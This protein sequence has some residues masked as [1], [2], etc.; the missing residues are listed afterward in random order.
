MKMKMAACC[1]GI[2]A[3]GVLTVEGSTQVNLVKE[4]TEADWP[5]F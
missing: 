3:H 4:L 5:S 1:A 2:S